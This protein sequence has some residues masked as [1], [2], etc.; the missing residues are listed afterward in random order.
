MSRFFKMA[1][2]TYTLDRD[3][4]LGLD[5]VFGGTEECLDAQVLLDPLKKQFHPPPRFV[6]GGNG[7]GRKNKV[8]GQKNKIFVGSGVVIRNTPQWFRVVLGGVD[9]GKKYG[10]V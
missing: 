3:P 6:Q 7:K 5:R 4:D 10:L 9:T 2:R 8:V 1:T